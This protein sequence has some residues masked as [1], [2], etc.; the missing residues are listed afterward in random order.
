MGTSPK[1]FKQSAQC[2]FAGILRSSADVS[3]KENRAGPLTLERKTNE[4][5]KIPSIKQTEDTL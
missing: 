4:L 2:S 5:R 3:K 1:T